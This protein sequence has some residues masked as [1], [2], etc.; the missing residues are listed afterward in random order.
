MPHRANTDTN[1]ANGTQPNQN[2]GKNFTKLRTLTPFSKN[3][4][5]QN[6]QLKS[7][8]FKTKEKTMFRKTYL[9]VILQIFSL[10]NDGV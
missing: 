3:Y 4:K 10:E 9:E 2:F 8:K 5:F 7:T 6:P 1:I